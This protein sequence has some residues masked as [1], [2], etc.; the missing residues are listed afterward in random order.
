[1]ITKDNLETVLNQCSTY[2]SKALTYFSWLGVIYY[3]PLD[4]AFT[5]LRTLAHIA[6]TGSSIVF[7][8]FDTA[9]RNLQSKRAQIG[10]QIGK[11]V[12]EPLQSFFDPSTLEA[13]IANLGLRLRENLTPSEIERRYFQ[14]RT[15]DYHAAKN[16]HF[17]WAVVK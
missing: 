16:I 2:N 13:D 3:L 8:Y 11:Q 17:A 10:R 7:D 4:T 12:G 9:A 15:D 6:P 14:G 1:L 5:T